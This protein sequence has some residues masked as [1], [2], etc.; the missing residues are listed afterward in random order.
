MKYE[1]I[2]SGL[3]VKNRARFVGQMKAGSI[4]LFNSNY[5]Y[6]WNGDASHSFKQNSDLFWLSGI[7]Q[8]DSI[9]V[10][11]PDCPVAEFR[12][13]LFL[14]QTNEHIAVWEGHKYTKEEARETSGVKTI[15]WNHEFKEKMRSIINMAG[16]IYLNLNEND[17]FS[18]KSPYKDMDFAREMRNEFPLHQYERASPLLQRLRSIK[19][20]IEL[21][22]MRKAIGISKKGFERILSFVKPGVMEY[23]I[24]AELIHEYIRNRATGHSFHPIVASGPSACVLH[25]VENNRACKDG[26]LVLVDCGVDYANYSSDMTRTFPVNGRFTKRQKDVYNA[27]L[28][29]MR[30]ASKL[31]VPGTLLMDYHNVVCKQ[32]MEKELVDLGLITMEDIRNEDPAWPA[33]KKYYM[34]GTSHFLGIEVHDVGMRYEPMKA[35]MVFTCEPGIYIPEEG[36]GIRIENNI[37]IT[38]KGPVDLMDETGMPIEAE[39]IEA[40]MQSTI[41]V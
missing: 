19:S 4:A 10:M 16:T 36:I 41:K 31:L 14:K 7:D 17:R 5:E 8:E 18:Y 40:I 13:V 33:L 24:E 22:L 23:E 3:F 2:D 21:D 12:E 11:F 25:Y 20:D 15:F 29:V 34:H 28:R 26:D 9:L 32:L 6:V 1:R 39:E 37:L 35:G 27:V 38:E 30:Q